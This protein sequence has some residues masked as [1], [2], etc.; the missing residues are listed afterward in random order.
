V[1]ATHTGTVDA[2][3]FRGFVVAQL[4]PALQ[5]GDIVI[6]DNHR[7]HEAEGVHTQIEARRAVLKPLLRYSPDLNP[8]EML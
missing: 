8:I 7:I 4:L 5:P 3:I 6:W 2:L 1:V